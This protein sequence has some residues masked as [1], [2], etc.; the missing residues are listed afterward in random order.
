[1]T[2]GQLDQG[3]GEPTI[4]ERLVEVTRK[5]FALDTEKPVN[6]GKEEVSPVLLSHRIEGSER[7]EDC[8]F[9][10]GDDHL[11]FLVS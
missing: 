1:V 10:R 9:C 2:F 11:V 4:F 3:S 5:G 6:G 7:M 8:R